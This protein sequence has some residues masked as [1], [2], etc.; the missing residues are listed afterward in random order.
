MTESNAERGGL[1]NSRYLFPALIASLALNLLVV[2]GIAAA[3]WHH[4]HRFGKHRGERGLLGFANDLSEPHRNMMRGA[5]LSA[6]EALRPQRR[7][8]RDAW[9]EANGTL[10]LEPF[11][12]A[13][14]KAAMAKVADVET[15][16]RNS[17]T[18]VLAN[19]AEK[20]TPDERRQLQNWR[21]RRRPKFLRRR[22]GPD[23]PGKDP[24]DKGD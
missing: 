6:R 12:K 22:H 15:A 8:I 20:L 13:K 4:H 1:R 7:A 24:G 14:F 17:L 19:T 16:F 21:D 9:D 11:D 18:D 3:A 23:D 10:T 5:V 2:G